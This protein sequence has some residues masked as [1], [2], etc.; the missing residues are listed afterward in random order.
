[1]KQIIC[2]SHGKICR[3]LD[4]LTIKEAYKIKRLGEVIKEKYGGNFHIASSSAQKAMQTA[5]ILRNS[6]DNSL[7]V[8]ETSAL[9]CEENHFTPEKIS[10]LYNLYN[11]QRE[12]VDNLVFVG[13]SSIKDILGQLNMLES[14]EGEPLKNLSS[15][16][17]LV[18]NLEDR[19]TDT[20]SSNKR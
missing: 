9:Y 18:L 17:A 1:M 2:V 12:R 5:S 14:V 19:T 7:V 13:S 15:M 8:E 11:S 4:T 3:P 10:R 20:I 6:I 16:S